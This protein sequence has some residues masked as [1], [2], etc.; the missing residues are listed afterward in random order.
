MVIGQGLAVL[1]AGAIAEA[2]GPTAAVGGAGVIGI[3]L[4]SVLMLTW[5][6]RPL[7][8]DVRDAVAERNLAAG[9][10]AAG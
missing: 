4:V 1:A 2:V 5:L 3:V 8:V 10:V 7:V 9:P 6:R